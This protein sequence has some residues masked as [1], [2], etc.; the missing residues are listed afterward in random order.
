MYTCK[1][2]ELVKVPWQ[3]KVYNHPQVSC[4][5]VL[6]YIHW[7]LIAVRK[8]FLQFI[9]M[10]IF[11]NALLKLVVLVVCF[12]L[13]KLRF[14]CRF[15]FFFFCKL[16][17]LWYLI[18]RYIAVIVIVIYICIINNYKWKF[19]CRLMIMIINDN[20]EFFMTKIM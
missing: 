13:Y 6:P 14:N 17:F 7:D 20:Y 16:F 1:L 18:F 10:W 11:S 2:T 12:V 19:N 5:Y 3:K 4:T 9:F 8:F 15:W